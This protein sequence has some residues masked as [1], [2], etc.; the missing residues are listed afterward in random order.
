MSHLADR[1][2]VVEA[3]HEASQVVVHVVK[4]HVDAALEVVALVGC[5]RKPASACT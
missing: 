4:D 3:V 5:T 1:K 2:L